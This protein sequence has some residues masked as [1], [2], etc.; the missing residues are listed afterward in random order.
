[1]RS[2]ILPRRL[3]G[4][5]GA[6]VVRRDAASNRTEDLNGKIREAT[7]NSIIRSV[8]TALKHRATDRWRPQD[9][10]GRSEFGAVSRDR[11]ASIVFGINDYCDDEGHRLAAALG[12]RISRRRGA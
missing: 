7:T 10:A 11:D 1:L 5:D 2:E 12:A 6:S 8:F 9:Q 3:Y 4:R